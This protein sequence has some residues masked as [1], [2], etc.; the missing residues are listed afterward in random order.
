M[1]FFFH[2][3]FR[4]QLVVLVFL[5]SVWLPGK[6][7]CADPVVV[8]EDFSMIHMGQHVD[9]L[10]DPSHSLAIKEL[11]SDQYGSAFKPH[12][13]NGFNYGMTGSII[14]LRFKISLDKKKSDR[15]KLVLAMDKTVFPFVDLYLPQSEE[16]E[17]YSKVLN[18]YLRS[19]KNRTWQYRYPVFEIPQDLPE[20]RYLFLRIS[21]VSSTNHASASFSLFLADED[22]F[23]QKTWFD[24]A[25]YYLLFGVLLSTIIY[26]AFL[27]IFLKDKVYYLY[28]LY[29]TFILAYLFLRSG[30]AIL[31]G[32]P[33]LTQYILYVVSMAYIFGTFFSQ[34]FLGVRK[35][36]PILKKIF[37]LLV[38]MAFTVMPLMFF[39]FPKQANQL[40]HITAVIGPVVM[41]IAGLIRLFQGYTPARYYLAAWFWVLTGVVSFA[42]IG[43]GVLPK[44]FF[45][46]N[47]LSIGST[48]E[49]VLLSTALGDRVRL[50]RQEKRALQKKER[51]LTELS[52]TDELTGLYNKRW[53]SS[54]LLSEIEHNRRLAQPLSLMMVDVDHFKRFN[55]TYGHAAGDK[56]LSK[57]GQ[58]INTSIRESDIPCRYGGEEFIVILPATDF[59]QAYSIAERLRKLYAS[60]DF[61]VDKRK[62]A[63]ST[64]SIGVAQLVDSDDE[65]TLFE[66]VDKAL[67]LAKDQGRNQVVTAV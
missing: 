40:I 28:V 11:L 62:R 14:W 27:C 54:K 12:K 41:F 51:R 35:H 43:L 53:F 20:N 59:E 6:L 63:R 38:G 2:S 5:L 33:V 45:T 49:A 46:L 17:I 25:F 56:V 1:N 15:Q 29:I 26:N 30:F 39:G 32:V 36:N 66:K 10:I 13:K 52:I 50:L 55:D 4:V 19:S 8:N 37:W 67:Y 31:A 24:I 23:R 48:L 34:S 3:R 42:L 7:Y 60:T 18:G 64:I 16:L 22:R 47:G 21:P 58:F 61:R 65:K 44:N 9:V 57:L